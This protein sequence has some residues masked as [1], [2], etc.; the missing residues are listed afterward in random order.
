MTT[1]DIAQV[2]S[3]IN[4][5]WLTALQLVTSR[6]A[7]TFLKTSV[8][9]HWRTYIGAQE[10]FVVKAKYHCLYV[11]E[12]FWKKWWSHWF[13][14]S[15]SLRTVEH[16][17]LA[18]Y[19]GGSMWSPCCIWHYLFCTTNHLSWSMFRVSRWWN[20]YTT[21]SHGN[22]GEGQ[23]AREEG[24][25]L[26]EIKGEE[27]E[28]LYPSQPAVMTT[29]AKGQV[30]WEVGRGGKG[31]NIGQSAICNLLGTTFTPSFVFI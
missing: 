11:E 14:P 10:G 4:G 27:E 23:Q 3:S 13:V 22:T 30:S 6:L 5:S 29:R 9:Q 25:E 7:S 2:H 1:T 18:S 28:S 31:W 26:E 24:E 21:C 8:V 17:T 15:N 16:S 12:Y 20:L 19:S